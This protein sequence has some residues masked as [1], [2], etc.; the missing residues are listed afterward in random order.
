M[1][2]RPAPRSTRIR[3]RSTP[4]RSSRGVHDLRGTAAPEP[5]PTVATAR[6]SR[7][8]PFTIG[9]MFV[10]AVVAEVVALHADQ[11]LGA[12]TV[13]VLVPFVLV[14]L[15]AWYLRRDEGVALAVATVAVGHA[16][17]LGS[18]ETFWSGL[19]LFD[20]AS[21]AA[22]VTALVAATGLHRRRSHAVTRSAH[23]DSLT[24]TLS[25]FGFFERLPLSE[26]RIHLSTGGSVL[27][28][29]LDGLKAVNDRR[30]HKAGD[31]LISAFARAAVTGLRAE[32]LIGRFGGDEFVLF[33]PGTDDFAAWHHAESLLERLRQVT[34]RPIAASIG[35]A[36]APAG[37]TLDRVIQH[38]DE[39]MYEAKRNGGDQAC[40]FH[41]ERAPRTLRAPL[42]PQD[43]D[44]S[45][46]RSVDPSDDVIVDLGND[47]RV[48]V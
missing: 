21:R 27:Y 17:W 31:E 28:L 8:S 20:L 35:I 4:L 16:F 5:G 18:G 44:T 46:D 41:F 2:H 14:V 47:R 37:A 38:A 26:D 19:A 9:A 32:D 39:A 24:G 34:P 11:V 7:R 40:L 15:G 30:G 42:A 1:Q 29:D 22:I 10:G 45:D 12:G 25:R 33:L 23:T 43:R 48:D 36:A 6:L 13:L 3:T